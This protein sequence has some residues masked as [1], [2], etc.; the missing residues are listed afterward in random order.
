MLESIKK[1]HRPRRFVRIFLLILVALLI[2]YGAIAYT[3]P[4]PPISPVM[5]AKLDLVNEP[6]PIPWSAQGQAAIGA[7][8][9][10]VLSETPH[11]KALP[12]ASVAKVFTAYMILKKRPLERGAI[13][14]GITIT[15]ADID[16]YNH[17]ITLGGSVLPVFVGQ[18][19]SQYQALQA[20]LLPSAN[21]I[22]DLL[23]NWA[24]GSVYDYSVAANAE[25]KVL[26]LRDTHIADASGFSSETVSTP[27]DLVLLGAIVLANPVIAQIVD[28]PRIQLPA[29]G[30]VANT[31]KLVENPEIIGIKTGHTNESGGCFL[32]AARHKVVPGEFVTVI[33]AIMAAPDIITALDGAMPLLEATYRGFAE[34]TL[35][36]SGQKIGEYRIPWGGR[37]N[38]VA[39]A[40]VR[41]VLWKGTKPTITSGLESIDGPRKINDEVGRLSIDGGPLKVSIPVVLDQAVISPSIKWRA[42]RIF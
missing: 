26:G 5:T 35:I 7:Q 14:P 9:Y 18:Q 23:G 16:I 13:G 32:F 37:V 30:T 28:L 41:E 24:Y 25:L 15:N 33:G 19:F 1:K 42:T 20:L 17:Y 22:A 3:N 11:Q 21:N 27:H 12:M 34:V 8:G 39:Q 36:K 6:V 4:L 40:D 2:G 38:V 31:N 29:V 10:G